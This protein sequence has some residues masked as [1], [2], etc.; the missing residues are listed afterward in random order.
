MNQG[1]QSVGEPANSSQLEATSVSRH[2]VKAEESR[3]CLQGNDAT[4]IFF[5]NTNGRRGIR[6]QARKVRL[7]RSHRQKKIF[8]GKKYARDNFLLGRKRDMSKLTRK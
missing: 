6:F 7:E 1:L 8:V 2:F 3:K 4:G 5:L